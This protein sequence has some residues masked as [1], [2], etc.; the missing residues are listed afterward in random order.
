MKHEQRIFSDP[1]F[2]SFFQA[3]DKPFKITPQKNSKTQ[4]VEFLVEGNGIDEALN[5]FYQDRPVGVLTFIKCLK[6]LRSSI[7]AL[8]GGR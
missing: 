5:E 3:I 7:F 4:Q 1:I 2:P 6:G 8:K